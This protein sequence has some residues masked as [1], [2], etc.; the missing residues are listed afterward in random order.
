MNL[1]MIM[2]VID[3]ATLNSAETAKNIRFLF[4]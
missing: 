4:K 1:I 2:M 3:V